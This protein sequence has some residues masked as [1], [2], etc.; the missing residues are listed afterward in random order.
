MSVC[1]NPLRQQ[2]RVLQRILSKVSKGYIAVLGTPGSGKSTLLTHFLRSWSG[3]VVRYYAFVPDSQDPTVLRGE[4][5]NFLHDVV[6]SLESFGFRAGETPNKFDRQLL[7]ERFH[8]QMQMAHEDW[9]ANGTKTII[10]VDG[11][12]HI[13]REQ[14]PEHSLINDLPL[15]EQVPDGVV[16]LVGS[17]TDSPLGA[18]IQIEV[19]QPSRRV[20]MDPLSREAVSRLLTVRTFESDLLGTKE[21]KF[22]R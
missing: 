7:L 15:P 8:K 21:V 5:V 3:R 17:Q 10:L 4:S 18:R 19:Q 11:L 16:M 14:S 9:K 1:T 22:T 20:V 2:G 13:D 6:L 12:D